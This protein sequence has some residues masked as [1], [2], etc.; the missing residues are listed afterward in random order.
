MKIQ[1]QLF[2]VALSGICASCGTVS[3]TDVHN[4]AVAISTTGADGAVPPMTDSVVPVGESSSSVASRTSTAVRLPAGVAPAPSGEVALT[5]TVVSSQFAH[6]PTFDAPPVLVGGNATVL[7]GRFVGDLVLDQN[8]SKV[9][10]A[11]PGLT[12]IDG[13]LIVAS[14]C[15]VVGLTVTGDVIFRGNNSRVFVDCLGQVLDYGMRN[16]HSIGL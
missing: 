3:N 14:Q 6:L 9:T 1:N 2:V 12:I 15:S 16:Q 11:G 8:R 10:G 4:P 7:G 13:N 5:P